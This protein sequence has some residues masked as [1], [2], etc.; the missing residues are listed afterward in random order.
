MSFAIFMQ[1]LIGG[2]AM[3]AIY[4]LIAVG[5]SMIW[6]SMGLLNFAQGPAV[7][8]SGFLGITA[9]TLIPKGTNPIHLLMQKISGELQGDVC[10]SR[11]PELVV[12][13]STQ[14]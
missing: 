8:F 1:Y 3:G 4:S 14:K 12:R 7:M 5:Y 11:H 9:V 13:E 6:K 10:E 2:L